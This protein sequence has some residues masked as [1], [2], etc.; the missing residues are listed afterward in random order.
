MFIGENGNG[1]FWTS[2]EPPYPVSVPI[3]ELVPANN[4]ENSVGSAI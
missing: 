4:F 2:A 3:I 1:L